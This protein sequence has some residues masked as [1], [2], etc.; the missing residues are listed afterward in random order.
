[1]TLKKQKT[2]LV[3][4]SNYL[5]I[6][7]IKK[8][9]ELEERAKEEAKKKFAMKKSVEIEGLKVETDQAKEEAFQTIDEVPC[10]TTSD[11]PDKA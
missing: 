9:K 3:A 5:Q 2:L 7:E 4:D 8:Q 11:H 10:P 6:R 1:M